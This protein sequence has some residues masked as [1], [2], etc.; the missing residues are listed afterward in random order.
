MIFQ[1]AKKVAQ[2]EREES[3]FRAVGGVSVQIFL[4]KMLQVRK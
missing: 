3:Q 1:A 2:L 4:A